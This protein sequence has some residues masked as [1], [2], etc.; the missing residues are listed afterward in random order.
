M[1]LSQNGCSA[2]RFVKRYVVLRWFHTLLSNDG[3]AIQ[4][5]R[6]E[7]NSAQFPYPC[8]TLGT[9][10]RPIPMTVGEWKAEPGDDDDDEDED[11]DEE[12]DD[13]EE[14]HPS[15]SFNFGQF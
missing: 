15:T 7:R 14:G 11:E 1:C 12:G 6:K 13:E 9:V 8:A 2:Q 5:R 4:P 10:R 3:T